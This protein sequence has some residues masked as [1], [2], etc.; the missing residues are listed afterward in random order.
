M[1]A[2]LE[3]QPSI[4]RLTNQELYT[5]VRDHL[6]L[7][8]E[9]RTSKESLVAHIQQ[10]A[11]PELIPILHDQEVHD[12]SRFLQVPSLE[13][14][15]KIY[16][17][18]YTA[19]SNSAV[20]IMV[21]GD[22]DGTPRRLSAIPNSQC[23]VPETAHPAHDLFEGKLSK[24]SPSRSSSLSRSYGSKYPAT[25]MK[26][27]VSTYDLDTDGIAA[28][29]A[30]D[31]MPRPPAVLASLITITYTALGELPKNWLCSTFRVRRKLIFDVLS[32]L[33]Q[34]NLKYYGNIKIDAARIAALPEDD[35]P[36]EIMSLVRQSTDTGIIDQES[37]GYVPQHD[38]EGTAQFDPDVIPL[39]VTGT[40]DTDLSTLSSNEMMTWGLENLWKEGK[41]GAY[42]VRHGRH[43]VSDFGKPRA[44]DPE[45]ADPDRPN[46]FE[47]V[48][49]CL[50]PYGRGGL[51]ADRPVDLNFGDHIKWA[52]QRHETFPFV[53]FGISQRR[54]ALMS[55]RI[56][57]RRKNFEK[58]ARLMAT[59]T[60]EKLKQACREEEQKLPISD[61]AVQLLRQHVHSTVGR[62]KG[63]N[64]SR[65][66]M[67]SQLWSTAVYMRPWNLWITI[68]PTDIHDPIAQIFAGENID[69]D[70]FIAALGPDSEKRA[71]NIAADP[72]AA[73]KFFHF[74]IRTILEILFG[75]EVTPF[76]VRSSMGILGE[77]AAYFGM[78]E[79]ENRASLHLHMLISFKHAPNAD[80]MI[81]LLKQDS[82]RARISAYIQANLRAHLPGL[83]TADLVKSIPTTKPDPPDYE[84]QLKDFELRL[85]R[86][87]QACMVVSKSG[88]LWYKRRAPFECFKE[89]FIDESGNWGPKRVYEFMN[90]WI[91]G[92][93][94]NLLTNGAD[95][96]NITFY[97]A[98]YA[99]KPQIQ[100]HN[101][102][103]ILAKGYAYH[104]ANLDRARADELDELLDTQWLLLF[105][106]VHAI[107]Q[108]QEL[109][110][111][112]V[113][114]YLMGWGDTY[115]SHHYMPI[116]WSSF[117][118]ALLSA[119][120]ALH[121]SRL[122]STVAAT[123][124]AAVGDANDLQGGLELE[125]DRD[126]VASDAAEAQQADVR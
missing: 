30:A 4:S 92:I 96:M 83:E 103:A 95:T 44:G 101:I 32:W 108:E 64:Q 7:P 59:I 94:L 56:Q 31:L 38:S 93:L 85:A 8:R 10:H 74:M 82:F 1:S 125:T 6:V 3:F 105:R 9:L 20:E 24:S 22:E 116:Y 124:E 112:V 40:I 19:T 84:E 104:L 57:M 121:R 66:I 18:Y 91:P 75:I 50:F 69:L 48:F 71:Q 99:I 88:R 11:S 49:P 39:H 35:V 26:G 89:D 17:S 77:V 55:A 110:A 13:Q 68:N 70:N 27:T 28:M 12:V 14:T 115:R 45:P 54:Q 120:P 114:S 36:W 79:A 34:N 58:Y 53:A 41:E 43:P 52:L 119:F 117:V 51:E 5:A 23:L 42:A 90:G 2:P 97:V 118:G 63:S 65:T 126:A 102:S 113:M 72:Y 73:A 123:D 47:K 62:V 37:A 78:V 122:S 81:A 21:C 87:E 60:P 111:P 29:L 86:T 76:H 15:K 25:G 61:P 80:E 100:N 98:G 16:H 33:K 46:F 107:N 109:G 106:L 67:R